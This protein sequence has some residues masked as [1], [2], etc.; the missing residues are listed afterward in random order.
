MANKLAQSKRN[1]NDMA[2]QYDES[3]EGIYTRAHKAELIKQ[4][5]LMDKDTVVDVA[6]GN[7]YL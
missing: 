2:A 1:Y 5:S 4:V 7:G 3:K 6:C